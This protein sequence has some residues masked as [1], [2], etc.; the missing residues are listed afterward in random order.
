M[1]KLGAAV[2]GLLMKLV[3]V[4][5]VGLVAFLGLAAVFWAITQIT[6]LSAYELGYAAGTAIQRVPYGVF[7]ALFIVALLA[8]VLVGDRL[9]KRFVRKRRDRPFS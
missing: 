8:I 3:A 6:G 2:F 7:Y 9:V 5:L 4:A 1:K